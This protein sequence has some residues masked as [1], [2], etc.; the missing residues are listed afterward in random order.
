[1]ALQSKPTTQFYIFSS[2]EYS[3]LQAYLINAALTASSMDRHHIRLCI[4]AL[5]QGAGLLQTT[6]QPL[7]LSGVLLEFLGKG[8]RNK[9]ELQGCLERMGLSCEGTLPEL[10]E[11]ITEEL[12]KDRPDRNGST[13]RRKELGQLPRVVVLKKA[14]EKLLALP[15]A[16]YWDLPEC[17]SAL[18]LKVVCPSDDE[19]YEEFVNNQSLAHAKLEQRNKCIYA[20]LTNVRDR[21]SGHHVLVN[22]AKALS[23]NFMDLC[24]EEN[25]RKLSFMQQVSIFI[26]EISLNH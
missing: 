17:T 3:A 21:V 26:Q 18:G 20:V 23:A 22:E 25:L 12:R 6:Y 15:I 2:A 19:I 5:A 13:A 11:R 14:I 8:Q 7:V 4:G 10:R 16:G 1:M 9:A 24:Q